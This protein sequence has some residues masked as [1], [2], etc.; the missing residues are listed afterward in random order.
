MYKLLQSLNGGLD[1]DDIDD[2][3]IEYGPAEEVTDEDIDAAELAKAR[4]MAGQIAGH[5]A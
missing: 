2:L 5:F 4:K 1:E 3:N